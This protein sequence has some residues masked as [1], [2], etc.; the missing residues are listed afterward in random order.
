MV[1]RFEKRFGRSHPQRS[2]R[3]RVRHRLASPSTASPTPPSRTPRWVKEGIER[4]RWM[5]ATNGGPG[6]YIQFGPHDRKGY[7][8]DFL[9]IS[10]LRGGELRFD[11]YHR[12]QWPSNALLRRER[13]GLHPRAD[14]RDRTQPCPVPAPHDRQLVPDRARGSATSSASACGP[15]S[16]PRGRWPEVVNMWEL[17]GWN[18]LAANFAHETAGGRDQ[19]PSLS[20]WW[21]AAASL[22]RGG[23]DRIVVPTSFHPLSRAAHRRPRPRRG[24]RPRAGHGATRH[25][26]C[27]ARRRRAARRSPAVTELG[28]A[29]VGSYAVAMA[30][31]SEALL[32]WAIPDWATWVAY[33]RPGRPR[34][35]WPPGAS[36]PGPRGPVEAPAADRRSAEPVAHRPPAPGSDRRPLEESDGERPPASSPTTPS[37][38]SGRASTCPSRGRS[39]RTTG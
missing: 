27:I 25:E 32:L 30:D 14:R 7:K 13:Q 22:R 29:H 33:E 18:G 35:H 6:T 20:E 36:A 28:L 23:V 1:E 10:E 37:T 39:R 9:T 15:R 34:G 19:D 12:P 38:A 2:R 16:A 31:D 26:R 4:I 17:D 24:L 21:A 5:P 3:A 11:G 8:G